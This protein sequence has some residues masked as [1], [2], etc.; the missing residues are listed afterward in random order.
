MTCT[1]PRRERG[2]WCCATTSGQYVLASTKPCSM[3]VP[4]EWSAAYVRK[5]VPKYFFF[6]GVTTAAATATAS[7]DI[8]RAALLACAVVFF[9]SCF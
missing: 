4:P 9:F 5:F 1:K 3:T 8:T 2:W 7:G 6:L